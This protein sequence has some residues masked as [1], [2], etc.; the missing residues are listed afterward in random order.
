MDHSLDYTPASPLGRWLEPLLAPLQRWGFFELWV[1]VPAM[2]VVSA[3]LLYWLWPRLIHRA[4]LRSSRHRW[5]WLFLDAAA[6]WT[7]CQALAVGFKTL[8]VEELD[9]GQRVWF[10]AWVGPL[11]LFIA[12]A[13]ACYFH[14]MLTRRRSS[15]LFAYGFA[16]L[17]FGLGYASGIFR[18]L[19]QS[20]PDKLAAGLLML[21]LFG[22]HLAIRRRIEVSRGDVPLE[23]GDEEAALP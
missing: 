14:L 17:A 13:M 7:G 12:A 20:W 6:A 2:T 10:E 21:L 9:Y 16:S 22:W 23:L 19:V 18:I 8:I 4:E 1:Y 5:L 15:A 11:H 3:A